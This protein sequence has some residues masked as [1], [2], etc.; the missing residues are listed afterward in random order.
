MQT[1]ND[2]SI[3]EINQFLIMQSAEPLKYHQVPPVDPRAQYG[4]H[5]LMAKLLFVDVMAFEIA[6]EESQVLQKASLTR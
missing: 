1:S 3:F 5:W 4:N 2:K 6:T